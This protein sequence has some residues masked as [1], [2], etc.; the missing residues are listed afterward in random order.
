MHCL[1]LIL[2]LLIAANHNTTYTPGTIGEQTQK[3]T[4]VSHDARSHATRIIRMW[5]YFFSLC[6]CHC[7]SFIHTCLFCIEATHNTT[8]NPC[9]T[10]APMHK[11][12][13]VSHVAKSQTP[14]I[15]RMCSLFWFFVFLLGFSFSISVMLFF[16]F[17]PTTTRQTILKPRQ[18]IITPTYVYM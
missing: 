17:Q 14:R 9:P 8:C 1:F 15:I 11:T 16:L 6:F 3:T 5:S 4:A 10:G 13:A 12:Q 18:N 2:L 7:Q